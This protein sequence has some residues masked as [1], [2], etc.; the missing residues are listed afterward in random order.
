MMTEI[1]G[2]PQGQ[3]FGIVERKRWHQEGEWDSRRGAA[4]EVRP[5]GFR[6]YWALPSRRFPL[7][8]IGMET[9]SSKTLLT[10]SALFFV[11]TVFAGSPTRDSKSL[12]C[13][14][15]AGPK[16]GSELKMIGAFCFQDSTGNYKITLSGKN[17]KPFEKWIFSS[18]AEAQYVQILA[19]GSE[20]KLQWIHDTSSE[21]GID[22]LK[23]EFEFSDLDGDGTVAPIIVYRLFA[24]DNE[25]HTDIKAFSGKAKIILFYKG[26]K[27]VIRGISG[28]LDEDRSTTA[29]A[30]YFTLP[31]KVQDHLIAKLKYMYDEGIFGFDNSHD[32]KIRK[33]SK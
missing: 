12:G 25:G 5:V 19:N 7:S 22:F 27:V 33:K 10:I 6:G 28:I 1:R 18:V 14:E 30:N 17:D 15:A 20:K 26:Q 29:T 4:G 16:T 24:F 2:L 3:P 9:I 32:F 23:D 31:Q 8:L 11:N 21:G 13:K